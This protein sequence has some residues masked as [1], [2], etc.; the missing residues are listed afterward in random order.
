MVCHFTGEGLP[1]FGVLLANHPVHFVGPS[2]FRQDAV[3]G[4]MF[5]PVGPAGL[6]E[7]DEALDNSG[8][9]G[10]GGTVC[11]GLVFQELAL[12]GRPL[13]RQFPRKRLAPA[14]RELVP[15]SGVEQWINLPQ[16]RSFLSVEGCNC[17][18]EGVVEARPESL[19][20]ESVL[21]SGPPLVPDLP[22][23][24]AAGNVLHRLIGRAGMTTRG[25]P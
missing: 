9:T 10:R 8:G 23:G 13:H 5:R 2:S 18:E 16:V 22:S 11:D 24:R 12:K 20:R 25:G 7:P 4:Q 3:V 17:D 19:T 1:S 6:V 21:K 15:H 14:Q